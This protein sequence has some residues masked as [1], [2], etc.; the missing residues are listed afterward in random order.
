MP[1]MDRDLAD[2]RCFAAILDAHRQWET[3][4]G[5]PAN[6]KSLREWS[7]FHWQAPRRPQPLVRSK[8]PAL[9]PLSMAARQVF[10][11]NIAGGLVMEHREPIK[12]VIRE[13]L[14][15]PPA[16]LGQLREVLETRLV[17][18]VITKEE[19]RAVTK[20]GYG[21]ALVPGADHDPWARYKAA[22]IDPDG[23]APL[24]L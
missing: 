5:L 17:C 18:C 9:I 14:N 12:L 22:G 8:Y 23:F 19:D 16:D 21:I 15:Q 1:R 7:W 24:E 3:E 4:T 10:S 13:L 20:A 6:I 11:N 2:L